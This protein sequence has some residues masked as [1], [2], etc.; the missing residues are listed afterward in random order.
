MFL[1]EIIN[2]CNSMTY[3]RLTDFTCARDWNRTSTLLPIRDFESRASTSSAT[4]ACTQNGLQYYRLHF[5][6]PKY[7]LRT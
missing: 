2:G 7:Y 4:R 5:T 3:N 1:T 6:S